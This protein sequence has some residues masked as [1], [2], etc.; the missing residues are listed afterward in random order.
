MKSLIYAHRGASG[1]APENT[2]A[3]FRL[4]VQQGA[5]G[6]E[7]DIQMSR[8]GQ[9]VVIHDESLDRTTN[10]KGLVTHYTSAELQRLDASHRF[11]QYRGES[12]P[13]LQEVLA[14]L[15]PTSL[16]LNIELKNG[17]ILYE[18]MEEKA[19]RLVKEYAMENRVVF[20]SFNHYSLV[21]LASLAPEIERG[22]LYGEGLYEPWNYAGS[23]QA[24]A[25]HAHYYSVYPEIVA[26]AHAAG[27]KIRPWTVNEDADLRRMI[28]LGV[29][30][31]ITNYPA[32]MKAIQEEMK[33]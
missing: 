9:L 29:D 7:L 16:E 3:A 14:Y 5:D 27:S 30:A 15:A 4:A 12:L 22:I 24:L 23:I 17:L 8:D 2:M 11:E 19:I 21:K 10:G 31:V 25:L 13:L 20:S 18:G 26:G 32:R 28:A 1:D 6:I 33:A